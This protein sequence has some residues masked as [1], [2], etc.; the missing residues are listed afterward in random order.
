MILVTGAGGTVGGEV[1]R[2]LS[3]ERMDFRAAFHSEVKAA[4]ARSAGLDCLILDFAKPETL[5]TALRGVT[6]VFLLSPISPRLAEREA[7]VVEEAKQAGVRHLVK[8]SVWRASEE[9]GAFA[10]W[11]RA[12]EK[13]IEESGL[14]FTFLRPNGFMQNLV[15]YFAESIRERQ[16]I[17]LPGGHAKVSLIDTRDIADVAARAL[18]DPGHGGRAYDLSGP[19]SLSYPQMAHTLS[20]VLGKRVTYSDIPE[21]D[22][23][24][25]VMER[26]APEW[27]ADGFIE[28]QRYSM[29]GLA[30][31][32]LGSVQQILGR[33]ATPFERFVRDHA[34]VFR[35]D[36]REAL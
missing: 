24:R 14:S 26:G 28:F 4:Q 15:N 21:A 5:R 18:S 25:G 12:S 2:S 19:E 13:H 16:A 22:F 34:R 10:R 35:Q 9:G 8:L 23:K 17:D 32:V 33:R 36:Q 6:Q 20:V 11:H 3:R 27:M 7:G 31:D 30:S 29:Q 1:I